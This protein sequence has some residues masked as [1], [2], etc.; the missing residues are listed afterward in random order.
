MIFLRM[1][2]VDFSLPFNRF[3]LSSLPKGDSMLSQSFRRF[4]SCLSIGFVLSVSAP[5]KSQAGLGTYIDSKELKSL[6]TVVS[7]VTLIPLAVTYTTLLAALTG[8]IP[9]SLYELIPPDLSYAAADGM[10]W[11]FVNSPALAI[12]GTLGLI[13]LED[14]QVHLKFEYL[15]ADTLLK[16]GNPLTEQ[17]IANYNDQ[18]ELLNTILDDVRGLIE[19]TNNQDVIYKKMRKREYVRQLNE[20][21]I[22]AIQKL[23]QPILQNR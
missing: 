1:R 2:C 8:N 4:F 23:V 11:I 13:G 20:H 19:T 15:D 16:L 5:Y 22:S 17:E 6:A 9:P 10:Q 12:A 21:T 7:E 3:H 18:Y 14:H